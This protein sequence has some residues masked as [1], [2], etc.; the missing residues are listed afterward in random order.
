MGIRDQRKIDK[1]LSEWFKIWWLNA[2][3]V[4]LVMDDFHKM[5]EAHGIKLILEKEKKR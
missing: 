5:L 2:P 4:P 3:N 1:A